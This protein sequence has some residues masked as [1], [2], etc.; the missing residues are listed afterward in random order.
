[1]AELAVICASVVPNPRH[2]NI[3]TS[4]FKFQQ[5]P[6]ISRRKRA[7][8]CRKQLH[9]SPLRPAVCCTKRPL[10]KSSPCRA[11]FGSS[12]KI[13]QFRHTR[14]QYSFPLALCCCSALLSRH[15]RVACM[16]TVISPYRCTLYQFTHVQ[17]GLL[18]S[19]PFHPGVIRHVAA[20]E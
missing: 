16:H 13:I 7:T 12:D 20:V 1:M 4:S 5:L 18:Y 6:L 3:K 19:L 10:K 11:S 17:T 15:S 8:L 2:A 14:R 9:P